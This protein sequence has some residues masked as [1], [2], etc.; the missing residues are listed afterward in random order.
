MKFSILGLATL[1]ISPV[2]A[3]QSHKHGSANVQPFGPNLK[4]VTRHY[5]NSQP[6]FPSSKYSSYFTPCD[7]E[8][9]KKAAFDAINKDLNIDSTNYVVKSAYQ[10]KHN[11]VTHV[12]LR[13]TVGGIEVVNGDAN[14]NIDQFCSVL[15]MTSSFY[16]KDQENSFGAPESPKNTDTWVSQHTTNSNLDFNLFGTNI[17]LNLRPFKESNNKKNP[18]FISLNE[19]FVKLSEH[20]GNPIKLNDLNT[21]SITK[22]VTVGSET[23]DL[24]TNLPSKLA[25]NNEA[26]ARPAFIQNDFGDLVPVWDLQ[27]EQEDDWWSAQVSAEDGKVVSLVNWAANAAYRVYPFGINDPSV[28]ERSL[29]LNPADPVASPNGWHY[30]KSGNS[31]STYGN[32]V[33]AQE[34]FNGGSQWRSNYRPKGSPGDTYDFPLDLTAE[35]KTYVNAAVTNLFY[36]NNMMHDVFYKYGFDEVSGNFQDDNFGRGGLGG[37]S[38]IANAQDGSGYNN[39]NFA[40][41]PDGRQPR[42][43]MYV[44]NTFKPMRDGDLDAGIVIHEYSHGISIRLTGGPHN[45]NCLGWGEA[46]GMGEGWG[47]FF[48]TLIRLKTSD[49]NNS[50][51]TMGDYAAGEGIRHYP[52]STS[53]E[54]NPAT[55]K[56][57]DKGAYWGVHP[58]GSVWAEIL[59]EMLWNLIDKHGFTTDLMSSNLAYGNTLALQ[60]VVDGMKLQPCRPG[61]TDARDAILLADKQLTNGENQCE[62]WK[63]FAKRGLGHGAVLENETPWGGGI[64][65]ESYK[66]GPSCES[67]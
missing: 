36:L 65:T 43:R 55:Y 25:V 49:T 17:Q 59:Y 28:G 57:L 40:T 64:R 32:N 12:Y 21:I 67:T 6:V 24:I 20:I 9:A 52:Y 30:L 46:G 4:K 56:Y 1:F 60:L 26:Y 18:T 42:M 54:I 39:A 47:D 34:N 62:I 2:F 31:T 11:K 53:M 19:A 14:I 35:P 10:S 27:V 5:T 51:F 37:D 29:L 33:Y 58:K 13:Q 50:S 44:W 38:V 23:L 15:S 16:Q 3:H 45:S 61:F 48:A 41:P 8:T 22:S 66:L 63:A 7:I